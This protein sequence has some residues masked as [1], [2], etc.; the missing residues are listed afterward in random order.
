MF[1]AEDDNKFRLIIKG[2]TLIFILLLMTIFFYFLNPEGKL[3]CN[4]KTLKPKTW[5]ED[6]LLLTFE[7]TYTYSTESNKSEKTIPQKK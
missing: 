5:T 4:L 3:I 1:H 2:R 6:F 7:I